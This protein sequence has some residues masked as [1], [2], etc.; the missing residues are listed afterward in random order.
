M[1]KRYQNKDW[2]NSMKL[3]LDYNNMTEE[4]VGKDGITDQELR[5]IK[6]EALNA[7]NKFQASKGKGWLGW[8]DLPY[9]QK[10]I[11]ADINAT[12]K[13]IRKTAKNFVVLGI[14]G[15]ALGPIAVFQALCHLR[16][17]DLPNKYRQRRSGKNEGSVRRYKRRGNRFQRNNQERR[18]LRNY[19]AISHSIRYSE[20]TARR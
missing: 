10:D 2:K 7:L 13:A 16:Y 11:V 9:N 4:F 12:A 3:R 19:D 17:N 8:T 6:Y 15:S 18:D 20:K 1:S 14:G 5:S